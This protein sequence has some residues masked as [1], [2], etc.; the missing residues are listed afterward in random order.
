MT[1]KEP[2][3]GN[4]RVEV[5]DFGPVAKASIDLRPL[6]VFVGPSNT[7]KSY[8]AVLLYALHRCLTGA[9]SPREGPRFL[10]RFGWRPSFAP[11]HEERLD[12]A[13]RESL[14]KWTSELTDEGPLP[15]LPPDVA[16]F[17]RPMLES[18][19]GMD[20]SLAGETG[21]CFG[22][23]DLGALVRRG[24]ASKRFRFSVTI[25]HEE[26]REA[27]RYQFAIGSDGSNVTGHVPQ[28]K[29]PRADRRLLRLLQ[30]YG[31]RAGLSDQERA[32]E[33][34]YMI[35]RELP[36]LLF[37]S[38]IEPLSQEA[39]YLPADRTGVMHSHQVV[40][41][42]LVQSATTA[43]LRP[44]TNVPVL[45][46]VLADFLDQLIAMGE[47]RGRR[48]RH[49][50]PRIAKPLERNLLEGTVRVQ[51]TTGYPTFAY[52]PEG[53]E[54]DLPLMRASSMVSEL[55]PVVLYL[56]HLVQP[57]NVL[58]IE[59]PEAHLHPAMQTVLARELARLVRAGVRIVITTHSDWLIEQIGNLVRLSGLAKGQQKSLSGTSVALPPEQVGLWLFTPNAAA[60]GSLVEEIT[61]DPETGLFPTDYDAVSEALYNEGAEI[62]NRLQE[63]RGE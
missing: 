52:R 41:G 33:L 21:R 27:V 20:A 49:L 54:D 2:A 37:S 4:Y 10:L 24:A 12:S 60:G 63:Q 3:S 50:S 29:E 43:G 8:M 28:L 30:L 15:T 34:E 19:D 5:T 32:R 47:G 16:D 39:Y 59:E 23:E 58:I 18:V 35:L 26:L 31:R 42:T 57:G 22:I 45:S 48:G 40:V 9:S 62:F 46:G 61:L 6:T 51:K 55:A 53:W 14:G 44:S 7:G 36:E 1:D 11:V 13:I 56:K 38:L 17:I 25:T